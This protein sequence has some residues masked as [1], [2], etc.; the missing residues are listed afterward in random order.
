M[1]ASVTISA[2]C[3]IQ[4]PLNAEMFGPYYYVEYEQSI[5]I[6]IYDYSIGA[7]GDIVIPATINGKPVTSIADGAFGSVTTI[8][9]ISI[10]STVTSIGARAFSGCDR[11]KSLTI[12]AGVTRIE[13]STF[14]GCS[15]LNSVIIPAGVTRIGSHAFSSCLVLEN[16]VLPSSVTEIADEAFSWC[17]LGSIAI[18]GNVKTLGHFAFSGSGIR[19]IKIPSSVTQI[20]RGL[21]ANCQELRGVEFPA[22]FTE[23]HNRMFAGCSKLT[24]IKIPPSVTGIG[25]GAFEKS[26]LKT[27]DLGSVE[28]IEI[29]AFNQCRGLS[30]VTI[31]R[32]VREIE[33]HAFDECENLASALF[34]GNAPIMGSAV[35]RDVAADFKIFIATGAEGY[36]VPRWEGYRT[37]LPTE[38]IAVSEDDGS[39]LSSGET[40]IRLGAV[41]VG[42]KG[43]AKRFTIRNVGARKLTRIQAKMKGGDS[44]EFILEMPNKSSLAPGKTATLEVVF[45]PKNKG[46]RTS[47]L[48]ILSSDDNENPFVIELSGGGLQLVD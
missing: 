33:N 26:G 15:A 20:G 23:I 28:R 17:K 8:T 27:I 16:L 21:F 19:T 46:K 42:R 37:S 24:Q 41:I 13:N 6:R 34:L 11:L 18:P 36:T 5:T 44:S 25:Q 47:Q 40:S 7:G 30:M 4:Q 43:D 14:W 10:P 1:F 45:E 22:N 3:L 31:P 35:F 32:S 39:C 9:G 2:L 29:A 38:E 12:P 48:Q